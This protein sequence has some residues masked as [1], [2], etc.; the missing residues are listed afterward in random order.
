MP[1]LLF[2]LLVLPAPLALAARTG[3]RFAELTPLCLGGAAVLAYLLGLMG[4]LTIAPWLFAAAAAAGWAYLAARLAARPG[5]AER[6]G[7]V[8]M[9]WQPDLAAFAAALALLWWVCQ[10]RR[11]LG[12][13][14]FSHW[15]LALKGMLLEDRL[16]CL[17]SLQDGFK[18]YPPA[19]S[20]FQYI[21]L[22]ASGLGMR[23]DAALFAQGIFAA[24]FLFYPLHRLTGVKGWRT[25]PAAGLGL[26]FVPLILYPNFYTETTADGLLGVVWGFVPLVWFLGR[27]GRLE[28]AILAVAAAQLCLTKSTGPLLAALALAVALLPVRG[29]G[30]R[31]SGRIKALWPAG[32]AAVFA[33][34]SWQLLLTLAQTP[35]RWS[36]QGL[37]LGSLWTLLVDHQPGWR[38]Q[39]IKSYVAN[40]AGDWN[41]GGLPFAHFPFLAFFA[42]GAALTGLVWRLCARADRA[43]LVTAMAGMGGALALYVLFVLAGYLFW[44]VETEALMLASLSRYLNTG[45][46]ACLLVLAGFGLT[47]LAGLRLR[48]ALAGTTATALLWLALTSPAPLTVL[49][50]LFH[51]PAEAAY[52]RDSARPYQQA[53]ERLA[54][55]PA[56]DDGRLNVYVVS[57]NDLGLT[58]LR[59]NYELAP[60]YLP[61][62]NSSLGSPYGEAD[63]WTWRCTPEEWAAALAAEYQYVYLYKADESFAAQF[64]P[65]FDD[66]A[67]IG[68]GNLFRVTHTDAGVRLIL[69]PA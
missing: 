3:R 62:H 41:Y 27:R 60:L 28:Q 30:L 39:V 66:A 51:A 8:R 19:A 67:C 9:L 31:L 69:V 2:A 45:V 44:F 68:N 42:L 40:L 10:G 20:L 58:N 22:K 23:E 54:S 25:L 53:A 18:E 47:A 46:L 5:G 36:P 26:L 38:V 32:A 49:G 61:E 14:E 12:W 11:F 37:S 33:A 1:L 16:S 21:L 15:G 59:L 48:G 4:A 13:D 63:I 64:A 65:L 17:T 35:R 34:G 7:F 55:L 24:G 50:A 57:Q 56:Q 29:G 43:P 52:T 6:T